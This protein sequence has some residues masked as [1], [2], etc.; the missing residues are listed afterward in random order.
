MDRT[1]IVLTSIAETC[2]GRLVAFVC[3]SARRR[4][5]KKVEDIL[6]VRY[7]KP[8][9]VVRNSFV[10]K[11][12]DKNELLYFYSNTLDIASVSIAYKVYAVA[13]NGGV[14]S[15]LLHDRGS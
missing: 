11:L 4:T 9:T 2:R 5:V 14:Q 8:T 1:F 7:Q 10:D 6:F 12:R 3:L 13:R 15:H